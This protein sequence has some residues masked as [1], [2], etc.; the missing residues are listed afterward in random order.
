MRKL[1]TRARFG[2]FGLIATVT[3]VLG[4]A[5]ASDPQNFSQ[6]ERGRYLAIA[7]DCVSCHTVPDGGV[8][9]AGGRAIE[10]PFGNLIAP[11]ITSDPETG[12]GAWT[13]TEFDAAVR[14]G[15]RPNGARLYPAMPFNAYTKMSRD[16][17]IAIRAYLNT[18]PPVRN[19]VVAN[20]LSFP[21]SIRSLMGVW[22]TLYFSAGE[23]KADPSQ[24]AEWNRGAFLVTGPG[25]F[26]ACHTPKSLLGGDK[27]SY[28]LGGSSLQGWFAPDITNESDQGLGRWSV[29][30]I[31]G[32]LKSGH[33][34]ISAAT[35]PMAEV[36]TLSTSHMQEP[37]LRAMAVYLK[38]VKSPSRGSTP[39]NAKSPVMVSGSAIYRDQCS[40]CHGL[41]GKGTPLLFPSVADSALVR[42]SDPTSLIRMVLRGARSVATTEEPTG[43]GM[44]AYG[45][46]LDDQQV[47]AVLTFLRNSWGANSPEVVAGDVSVARSRLAFRPD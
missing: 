11:N 30:D 32:Y 42:S 26:G 43:P 20:A 10:T 31:V 14:G 1:A 39:V 13:D 29:E 37:D 22:D 3:P 23:Y 38:S 7:S 35:G 15:L 28:A 2:I 27:A 17:V 21:F 41:D 5:G 19:A 8:P 24:S 33:N 45:W 16:D 40:A 47:A 12:V 18:I 44:P 4:L 6:I 25:H 9:Y 36:V 34:R 46:E